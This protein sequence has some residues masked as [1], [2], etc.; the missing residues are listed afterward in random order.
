MKFLKIKRS[1]LTLT[2][3]VAVTGVVAVL[4]TFSMPA[5][6]SFFSAIGTSQGSVQSMIGAGLATA[7][8]IAAKE[9]R[10]A[11]V[12][13][14]QDA[15]GNQYMIFIV[16][17]P[18]LVNSD[19]FK[20]V[21]GFRAI[22]GQNPIRIAETF[23]VMDLRLGASNDDIIDEDIEIDDDD[24][25]LYDTTTFSIIFSPSGKL[26]IRRVQV[27]RNNNDDG[28]FNDT[29]DSM[30]EDDFDSSSDSFT[31][32]DSRGSFVIYDKKEFEKQFALGRAYSEYLR[33]LEEE[34][35]IHINPYMGTII[36]Q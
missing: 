31:Q 6:Q 7:R 4:T 29:I 23:G 2:E 34:E 13:F 27:L 20:I 9:H 18:T 26:V 19:N 33:Y 21:N 25:E 30:F 5:V 22:E 12:R 24:P 10:Y 36:G 35:M 16:N 17:D 8:A 1:G 28:I 15:E 32:E 14:Q 3:M 11:G